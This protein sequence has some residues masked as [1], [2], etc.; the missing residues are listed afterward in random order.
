MSNNPIPEPLRRRLGEHRTTW[1]AEMELASLLF[2]IRAFRR[3]AEALAGV[4]LASERFR[5]IAELALPAAEVM[6]Q[7][8]A[9]LAPELAAIRQERYHPAGAYAQAAAWGPRRNP[10][11]PTEAE[12]DNLGRFVDY[13][14][15]TGVGVNGEGTTG[16]DL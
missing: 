9:C 3:S 6:R 1:A 4:A 16:G 2:A 8:D 12:R 10:W 13:V 14:E 11:V 7:P 5:F 15:V